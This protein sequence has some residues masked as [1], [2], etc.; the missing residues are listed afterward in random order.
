MWD[1]LLKTYR[2]NIWGAVVALPVQEND[3]DILSCISMYQQHA[4][5]IRS[6]VCS[7]LFALLPAVS[8]VEM[9]AALGTSDDPN[10]ITS[11]ML[12]GLLTAQADI[13]WQVANWVAWAIAGDAVLCIGKDFHK[14]ILKLSCLKAAPAVQQPPVQIVQIVSPCIHISGT[15][16]TNAQHVNGIY[17]QTDEISC[18]QPV[19][20]KRDDA[21][22]CIHFWAENGRWFIGAKLAKLDNIAHAYLQ[23]SGSLESAPSLSAWLIYSNGTFVQ[24]ETVRARFEPTPGVE[25]VASRSP[26]PT[27]AAAANSN[28]VALPSNA[29][30]TDGSSKDAPSCA[31]LQSAGDDAQHPPSSTSTNAASCSSPG[32]EDHCSSDSD[33]VLVDL[34]NDSDR[35]ENFMLALADA[36][37]GSSNGC[38]MLFLRDLH[39]ACFLQAGSHE[40]LSIESWLSASKMINTVLC[41]HAKSP[42]TSDSLVAALDNA[43]AHAGQHALSHI[44]EECRWRLFES[45]TEAVLAFVD[46]LQRI[47]AQSWSD[48]AALLSHVELLLPWLPCIRGLS[49]NHA[50][51]MGSITKHIGLLQLLLLLFVHSQLTPLLQAPPSRKHKPSASSSQPSSQSTKCC[52]K[53]A[54]PLL[55]K[56]NTTVSRRSL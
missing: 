48:S 38:S 55:K 49:F 33:V 26:L 17:D 14:F 16:G 39:A 31:T 22:K 13:R 52:S 20:I 47:P 24:Q 32:A 4:D 15:T 5:F 9:M 21:T 41:S 12:P 42:T 35:A 44:P 19:Y 7:E 23:H 11:A 25:S 10:A 54:H 30:S 56:P 51:V 18:G 8:V 28:P 36:A 53:Y 46:E 43:R 27:A 6:V 3:P 29:K 37:G 1:H 45:M 40:T 50:P 34:K 2:R